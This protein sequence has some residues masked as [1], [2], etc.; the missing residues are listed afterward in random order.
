MTT[1]RTAS[2]AL[3]AWNDYPWA[4]WLDG[5][6][7][8]LTPGE[9]FTEDVNTFRSRAYTKCR[10]LLGSQYRVRTKQ[11]PKRQAPVLYLQSYHMDEYVS[12]WSTD[13][14]VRGTKIAPAP[15]EDWP[16]ATLATQP[17]G[18]PSEPPAQPAGWTPAPPRLP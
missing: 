3:N 17:L 10:Q 11:N 8:A 4:Q 5:G 13:I 1:R 9:D 15:G 14:P 18:A 6:I 7:W 16:P 12:P 2:S